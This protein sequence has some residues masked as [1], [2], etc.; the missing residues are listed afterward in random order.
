[1]QTLARGGPQ[2][3]GNRRKFVQEDERLRNEAHSTVVC[4]IMTWGAENVSMK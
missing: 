3:A 2:R 1:M 4:P